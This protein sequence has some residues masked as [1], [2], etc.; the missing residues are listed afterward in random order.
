MDGWSTQEERGSDHLQ[1]LVLGTLGSRQPPSDS[2]AAGGRSLTQGGDVGPAPWWRHNTRGVTARDV[3]VDLSAGQT[4]AG[5][6]QVADRLASLFGGGRLGR[7]D[8]GHDFR[9]DGHFTNWTII[10]TSGHAPQLSQPA[11]SLYP[12]VNVVGEGF[13]RDEAS[14]ALTDVECSFFQD[15]LTLTDDHQRTPAHFCAL[16]DVVLHSLYRA[17]ERMIV[18]M[19]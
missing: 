1:R 12:L 16:E 8:G 17:A 4:E 7:G 3:V 5:L 15:N 11:A 10:Q 2:S 14:T 19:H 18:W 9:S 6:V 13:S